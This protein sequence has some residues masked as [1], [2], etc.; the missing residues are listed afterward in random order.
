MSKSVTF[1]TSDIILSEGFV[2][3]LLAFTGKMPWAAT[4]ITV[5]VLRGGSRS[6]FSEFVAEIP[7]FQPA[8]ASTF[9]SINV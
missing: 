5:F 6:R 3:V 4:C 1:K 8:G 9:A 2:F 7:R